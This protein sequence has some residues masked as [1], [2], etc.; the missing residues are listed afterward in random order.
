MGKTQSMWNATCEIYFL[1][2]LTQE[3]IFSK[4]QHGSIDTLPKSLSNGDNSPQQDY[5][6]REEATVGP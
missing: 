6:K 3:K 5:K 1:H 4:N 2:F